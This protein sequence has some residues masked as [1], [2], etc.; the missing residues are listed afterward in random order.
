MVSQIRGVV[1]GAVLALALILGA[2]SAS[3]AC[4]IDE[5]VA[6][7]H[8]ARDGDEERLEQALTC[9][10]ALEQTHPENPRVLAYLGSSYA[11]KARAS[12]TSSNKM[13][14]TNL[15]FDSLD[16]AVELSP[17]SFELRLIRWNVN[18]A[19]PAFFGRKKHALD[20]L[21]TLDQ[22]FQA[23]P[24]PSIAKHMVHVYAALA[25]KEPDIAKWKERQAKAEHIA[26]DAP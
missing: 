10:E 12:D 23:E 3:V 1:V 24:R 17:N 6:L 18:E 8:A 11:M 5:G 20:D 4:T 16:Y 7:H 22:I 26:K 2:V 14:F 19:V 25:E 9:F 15:G 21:Y 13:R